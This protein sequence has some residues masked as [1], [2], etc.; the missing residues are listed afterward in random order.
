MPGLQEEL[1]RRSGFSACVPSKVEG[2]HSRHHLGKGGL[3]QEWTHSQPRSGSSP[4]LAVTGSW[5]WAPFWSF[6][7]T[8]LH[9]HILPRIQ[10]RFCHE[11]VSPQKVSELTLVPR[12]PNVACWGH[13]H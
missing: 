13:Q 12:P 2:S 8:P 9:A 3:K 7:G 4:S 5:A 11:D 10:D 6:S 1:V